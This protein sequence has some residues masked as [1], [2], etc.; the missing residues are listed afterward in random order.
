MSLAVQDLSPLLEGQGD[1]FAG[2]IARE[3]DLGR[4]G[5]RDEDI[6][7]NRC[8]FEFALVGALH[9]ELAARGEDPQRKIGC[10]R[11]VAGVVRK[12]C[13]GRRPFDGGCRSRAV[14]TASC[15]PPS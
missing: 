13:F 9:E 4:N 11:I 1:H 6:L 14:R 5:F 15:T 7:F 8:E 10:Q 2:G 3:I 12:L